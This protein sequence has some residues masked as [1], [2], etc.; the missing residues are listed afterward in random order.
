MGPLDASI[1][2]VLIFNLGVFSLKKII[3]L[4]YVPLLDLVEIPLG[5]DRLVQDDLVGELELL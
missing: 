1:P 5:L 4:L 2:S 3:L